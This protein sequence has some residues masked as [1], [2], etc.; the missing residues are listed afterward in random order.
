[1]YTL[2]VKPDQTYDVLIDQKSVASGS[3]L[4]HWNFL[5]P[6]EIP[7]P[8]VSKP[9]D[10][11]DEAMI[12]DPTD[13][14]PADWDD[15]PEFIAD[16]EAE[17][18]EDWDDE[19]DGEWEAPTIPNPDYKGEWS[20]RMIENPA[21]KGE[22]VHPLI[23]NPAYKEDNEIYAFDD[24]SFVGIDIWQVKAG[25][26]FDNIIITDDLSEA[27]EH[28]AQTWGKLKTEEKKKADE[29]KEAAKKAEEE[30]ETSE[31]A[32]DLDDA[33]AAKLEALKKKQEHAHDDL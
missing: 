8:N 30:K 28:A 32:D 15:V 27:E 6:K 10:W 11:V 14:K 1:L 26:I 5:P 13:S 2:V 7:D 20:P 24:F 12:A 22:W 4:E 25:S 23:A 31:A 9:E 18:P 21:Y 3:I 29:A 19:E 33:K 17:K 16:P